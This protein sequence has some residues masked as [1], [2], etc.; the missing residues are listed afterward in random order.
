MESRLETVVNGSLKSLFG[1][2]G[3]ELTDVLEQSSLPVSIVDASGVCMWQNAAALDFVGDQRGASMAALADD[4]LP[5]ARGALKRRQLGAD[6]FTHHGF[7]VVDRLGRRRH[8]ETISLSLR[9][10]GEFVGI[11]SIV[12]AIAPEDSLPLERLSPRERETLMLLA[13]GLSTSEIAERLGIAHETVRNH[14]R[15]VLSALGVHSRVAAV[16]RAREL[17]LI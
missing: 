16:A 15:R 1:T 12:K 13:A 9:R 11:L 2:L 17:R 3:V 6:D 5:H 4:Y 7:V 14:I 10:D 8:I